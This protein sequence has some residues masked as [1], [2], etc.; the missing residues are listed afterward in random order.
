MKK[1]AITLELSLGFRE[2][3]WNLQSQ[4]QQRGEME[5]GRLELWIT[6]KAM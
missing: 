4:S 3:T 6:A 1:K 2:D 5:S